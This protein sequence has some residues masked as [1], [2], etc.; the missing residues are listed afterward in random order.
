MDDCQTRNVIVNTRNSPPSPFL[1]DFAQCAFKDKMLEEWEAD[2][3]GEACLES[4]EHEVDD[5]DGVW[6]PE[7]G[8]LGCMGDNDNPGAIGAVMRGKLW[9]TRGI[10]VDIQFPDYYKLVGFRNIEVWNLTSRS[11]WDRWNQ[12]KDTD[13]DDL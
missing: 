11:E 10:K 12:R 5:K 13:L 9:R 6:E 3:K 4:N 7:L 2:A 8:Y 1:I